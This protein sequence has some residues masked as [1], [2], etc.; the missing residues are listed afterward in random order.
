MPAAKQAIPSE[1]RIDIDPDLVERYV[2]GLAEFGRVGESGVSRTVYSPEWVAATDQYAEWCR[3]AGLEPRRDAVGNVFGVL[4]GS[5]PGGSYV[6]G[7]HIDSQTPGGRYDG[8]LGAL[9]ALIA[10]KA[11]RERY[12]APRRTLEALAFCEEESS[13]FP[14]A[15]FW[16]SRAI[17]GRIAPGD[18]DAVLGFEGETIGEAMR[19]VGLD[20]ERCH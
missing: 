8:A 12:G 1:R 13:R 9:A 10:L 19:A 4:A 11:L 17:T 18:W 20:P 7:S 5:E 6:S 15:N 2:M 14:N 16:G 3:E